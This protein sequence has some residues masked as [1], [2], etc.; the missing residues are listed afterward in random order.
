MCANTRVKD[1]VCGMMV[2]PDSHPTDYQGQPFAFCSAQCHD[3]FVT[4]PH[5]YIGRPGQLAP[6]QQGLKVLKR[7]QFVLDKSLD[8]NQAQAL[9]ASI[10]AMMGIETLVIE[11]AH[12]SVTYDLLQATAEQIE[13]VL[14]EAGARLGNGWAERLR[15]GFVH[16]TEECEIG[17]L[18]VGPPSGC[19]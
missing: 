1:V 14:A 10:S 2:A 18:Q 7:R 17:Q 16:Y 8:E 11:G 5:L 13:A 9:H 19:H 15:R 12:M 6:K 4:N 3:R